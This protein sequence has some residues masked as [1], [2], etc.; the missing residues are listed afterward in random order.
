MAI[1]LPSSLEDELPLKEH[2][3]LRI[4]G[5][6]GNAEFM[7]A[8]QPTGGG[9]YLMVSKALLRRSGYRLGELAMVRFR[10]DDQDAVDVPEP[11]REAL[12]ANRAAKRLWDKATPGK[13]RGLAYYVASAKLPATVEKRIKDAFF[14]LENGSMP[15]KPPARKRTKRPPE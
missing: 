5:V 13:R 3:R 9:W 14:Y 7:G 1:Y 6:I 12:D 10:I 11:L 4:R 15:G 2:P 8:W